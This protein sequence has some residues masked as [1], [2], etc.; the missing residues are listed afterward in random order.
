V[1]GVSDVCYCQEDNR[2]CRG[3]QDVVVSIAMAFLAVVVVV[4]CRAVTVGVIA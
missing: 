3:K 1:V 4:V 2:E